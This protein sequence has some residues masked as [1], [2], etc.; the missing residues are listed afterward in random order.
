MGHVSGHHGRSI[1]VVSACCCCDPLWLPA[2]AGQRRGLSSPCAGCGGGCARS[3]YRDIPETAWTLL[4][5]FEGEMYARGQVQVELIDGSSIA[6]ETYIV[7]SRFIDCLEEVE[8]DF[9]DFLGNGKDRF[10]MS[11]KGYL[12]LM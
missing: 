4:D 3:L 12:E 5:R 6:V 8:W 9:T 11:Y 10:R 7:N 1:G 2:V